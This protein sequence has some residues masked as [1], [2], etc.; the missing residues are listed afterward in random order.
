MVSIT[1]QVHIGE[2]NLL[3]SQRRIGSI[4]SYLSLP[5]DDPIVSA[6]QLIGEGVLTSHELVDGELSEE[7]RPIEKFVYS[8]YSSGGAT[9]IPALRWELFRSRNLEGEKLPPTR[10]ILMPHILIT[11]QHCGCDGQKL[12]NASTMLT[13]PR[14]KWMDACRA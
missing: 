9:T 11:H 14:P 6:F 2:G 8:V 13:A 4:I 5:N 3:T 12:Y 1:S 7:V 10:A